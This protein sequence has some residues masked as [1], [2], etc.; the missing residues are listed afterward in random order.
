MSNNWH[1]IAARFG[2][3]ETFVQPTAPPGTPPSNTGGVLASYFNAIL[4][5]IENVYIHHQ[6]QQRP[7]SIPDA[8]TGAP[9]GIPLQP[10][11]PNQPGVG[12]PG[13]SS[14]AGPAGAIGPGGM[15]IIP[16]GGPTAGPAGYPLPGAL[17]RKFGE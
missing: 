14:M 5:T 13:P 7:P 2:L 1:K 12:A 11:Q 8:T 15:P 9:G 17:K 10:P 16:P 4:G 6:K 3:P